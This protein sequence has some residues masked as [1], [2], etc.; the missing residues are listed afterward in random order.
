MSN[1]LA[2]LDPQE[3]A[4]ERSAD[5]HWNGQKLEPFSFL[6]K[7]AAVRLGVKW[8]KLTPADIITEK[9]DLGK[10]KSMDVQYYDDI[11][12]DIATVLWLCTHSDDECRRARRDTQW[13]EEQVDQWSEGKIWDSGMK[14]N[15]D[16]WAAFLQIVNDVTITEPRASSEK[17]TLAKRTPTRSPKR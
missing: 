14:L 7:T 11:G 1:D 8:W 17:K 4:F 16:A 10:G 2:D 9:V 13:G 6:R 15:G 3:Q 12:L 5:M